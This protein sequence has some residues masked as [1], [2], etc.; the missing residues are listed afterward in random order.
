MIKVLKDRVKKFTALAFMVV[1][2]MSVATGCSTGKDNDGTINILCTIFPAYDWVRE[3]TAGASNVEVELLVDS[4]ADMHS[5]Q[6]SASDLV[7]IASCDVFVYVGGVSDGWVEDALESAPND[8]RTVLNLMELLPEERKI[9]ASSDHDHEDGYVHTEKDA[10]DEHLWLS[11]NSAKI[12][13]EKISEEISK[14][15]SVNSEKYTAN[16]NAYCKALE[17]LDEE[18]K[19]VCDNAQNKTLVFGGRFPFAYLL[20]DYGLKH[21]AAFDGCSAESEAS[22]DTVVFLAGKVDELGA[23]AVLSVKDDSE[24]LAKTIIENTKLKNQ[25]IITLD[26]IQAVTRKDI[27]GGAAYL[28]IMKANLDAIKVALDY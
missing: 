7:K 17:E 23:P 9:C 27:D 1:I 10:Y 13:C 24:A 6:A 14:V 18:Y 26:S 28:K 3:I 8:K 20:N 16:T 19:K 2:F 4:G 15:D 22:F 5:Y 11:I 12:L 25:Q 21:Y